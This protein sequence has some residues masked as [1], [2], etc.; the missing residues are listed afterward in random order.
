MVAMVTKQ[1]SR[2]LTGRRA[3]SY[4]Y[5]DVRRV[6][7]LSLAIVRNYIQDENIP[8]KDRVEIA[9]RFALK[10]IPDQILLQQ[11]TQVSVINSSRESLLSSIFSV[12][13]PTGLTLIESNVPAT[14]LTSPTGLTSGHADTGLNSID[15]APTDLTSTPS[16]GLTSSDNVLDVPSSHV[17]PAL[18]VTPSPT[19][20][21]PRRE[22]V[23]ASPGR[24]SRLLKKQKPSPPIG[25]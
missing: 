4:N 21:G 25:T 17:P 14:G 22:T 8:Q 7:G 2:A 6:L 16:S 11:S 12:L 5:D 23:A 13:N 18:S 9:S 1:W 20:P 15:T 19:V 3:K 10:A 24:P